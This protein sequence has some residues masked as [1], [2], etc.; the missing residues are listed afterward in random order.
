M[1]QGTAA[2][3][4]CCWLAELRRRLRA[5]PPGTPSTGSLAVAGGP[6]LV[7]FLHDE[8]VV[9]CPVELVEEVSAILHDSSQAATDLLFGT[10]PLAFPVN[11]SVVQCYADAK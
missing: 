9:H 2:E 7:A 1:V 8:V 4:A 11:V 3:W 5:L 6:Q 10:I